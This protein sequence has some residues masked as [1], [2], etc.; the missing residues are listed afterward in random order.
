MSSINLQKIVL[1]WGQM[2]DNRNMETDEEVAK[3]NLRLPK[4]LYDRVT[5]RAQKN[6]RSVNNE[7]VIILDRVCEYEEKIDIPEQLVADLNLPY[8]KVGSEKIAGKIEQ[9]SI[10]SPGKNAENNENIQ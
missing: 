1:F 8:G 2:V 6:R 4:D 10:N 7:I 9:K 3:F 5:T